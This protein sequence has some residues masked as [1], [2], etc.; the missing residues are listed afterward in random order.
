[1][2]GT[3]KSMVQ[4]R[5]GKVV[6]TIAATSI[7]L[8]RL[9]LWLVYY[10]PRNLRQHPKW[11]Y[12]QAIMHRLIRTLLYH[13][14]LMEVQAPILWEPEIEKDR[15]ANIEP[16]RKDIY[17]GVL[18]DSNIKPATTGGW[19]FPSPYSAE[20]NG[21][22]RI[23]L[24]FHGGAFVVGEGRADASFAA[25]TLAVNL[26]AKVFSLSYRLSSNTTWRFPAALQ[27]AVTA[28]QYLVDLRTDAKQIIIAGDSAGGNL[29]IAL[30]RYIE[31][32]KGILPTPLAAVICSPWLDLASALEPAN[33][34]QHASN[35]TDYLV[36]NFAVWGAK[37]YAPAPMRVDNPYISPLNHPFFTK[38]QL[39]ICVGGLE[40]L[41]A[42][43]VRFAENMKKVKGNR[44]EVHI[45]PYASH[46]F[47]YVGNLTGF[48][49]EATHAIKFANE[50]ISEDRV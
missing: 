25:T 21:E 43:G 36:G 2:V 3:A 30:L 15:F 50:W 37:A 22:S 48:E 46:A 38:S 45:E 42:D 49:S 16:A 10:A 12:V 32:N 19:W 39:W 13:S 44:V 29:A 35:G 18:A 8:A 14:A 11:T 17:Q 27:D 28:Y 33:V 1:M 24:Y 47:L 34:D 4:S 5:L 26:K 6:W 9:P 20:V 40:I 31:D 23:V 41:R 7:T